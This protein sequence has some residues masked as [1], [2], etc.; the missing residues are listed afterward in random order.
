MVSVD[1]GDA[2]DRLTESRSQP[3]LPSLPL[4]QRPKG[5]NALSSPVS[6]LKVIT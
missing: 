4:A 2:A 3:R 6:Q 1:L 5:E